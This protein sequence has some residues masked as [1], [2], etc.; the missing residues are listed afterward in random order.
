MS[1]KTMAAEIEELRRLPFH[2]LVARYTELWGHEPAIKSR[3]YVFRRTAWKLQEQRYG[4]LSQSAQ[5]RLEELIA[6]TRTR[7]QGKVRTEH[8]TLPRRGAGP[9]VGTILTRQ[10]KGEE[11]RVHVRPEGFE[12][13]GVI[14]KSL[15]AVARAIT[16]SRWNGPL[17]FGLNQ[18]RA[19]T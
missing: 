14:F 5:D 2:Q 1:E 9:R 3:S 6:E 19:T 16:G 18:R 12:W 15:S 11:I 13:N 4:G 8:R 17:F 10:Y 7:L